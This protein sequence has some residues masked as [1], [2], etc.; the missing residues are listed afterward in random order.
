MNE[1]PKIKI[2]KSRM[3]RYLELLTITIAFGSLF[4]LIKNYSILPNE[5][6]VHFNFAG[7]PDRMSYKAILFSI[8]LL[9]VI[10]AIGFLFL[11][12]YPH[13]FNYPFAI[14]VKNAEAIY[15][16]S[17]KMLRILGVLISLLL[18]YITFASISIALEKSSQL[19]IYVAGSIL[20]GILLNIV[21][22]IIRLKQKA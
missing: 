1:R 10:I 2:S 16:E 7:M 4:Y 22:G 17:I 18:G 15:T 9:N 8:P 3:A 13:K 5:V 6:P 20:V 21:F 14:S 19:N 11:A 12:K